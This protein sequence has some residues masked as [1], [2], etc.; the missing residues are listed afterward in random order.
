[1]RGGSV[2]AVKAG[3]GVERVG[4]SGR[5]GSDGGSSSCGECLDGFKLR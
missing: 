4:G 3:R 5:G 2:G 1:M